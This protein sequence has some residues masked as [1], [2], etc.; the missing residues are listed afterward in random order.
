MTINANPVDRRWQ[1]ERNAAVNILVRDRDGTQQRSG[2]EEGISRSAAR[3]T[4]WS[5]E[6]IHSGFDRGLMARMRAAI[7]RLVRLASAREY[8][9]TIAIQASSEANSQ[10]CT[11]AHW[12][13]AASCFAVLSEAGTSGLIARL[14]G[15]EEFDLF[16]GGAGAGW[17]F[18]ATVLLSFHSVFSISCDRT[19]A[20][21][22]SAEEI[23]I[24]IAFSRTIFWN[25]IGY[26]LVRP[27][28]RRR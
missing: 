27:L 7:C 26:P 16:A 8:T 15:D 14:S 5:G 19:E 22:K 20:V 23:P 24:T 3:G 18:A 4:G 25:F 28:A 12:A 11:G 2:K 21:K 1:R 13:I 17:E 10:N 9:A 6:G